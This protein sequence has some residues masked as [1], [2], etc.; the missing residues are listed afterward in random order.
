MWM[1]GPMT[2]LEQ[3]LFHD[4]A[5]FVGRGHDKDAQRQRLVDV[6]LA[7]IQYAGIVARQYGRQRRGHAR[8]VGPRN[9][10]LYDF[11]ILLHGSSA[12]FLYKDSASC[13]Q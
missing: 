4:A 7:D 11:D 6:G 3:Q 2:T 5:R 1:S 13:V 8:L 10:D 12:V 9:V